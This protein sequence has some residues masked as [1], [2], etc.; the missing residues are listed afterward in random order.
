MYCEICRTYVHQTSKHCRSCDRCVEKFDHHCI[1]INNCIGG[2]NYKVFL[3]MICSAFS[4]FV[5]HLVAVLL[6]TTEYQWENILGIMIAN[7]ISLAICIVFLF[8]IFN[9]ILLHVY[10]NCI[11]LTTYE[12]L[13]KRKEEEQ[14]ELVEERFNKDKGKINKLIAKKEKERISE[15]INKNTIIPFTPVM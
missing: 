11:G 15:K 7:W 12:F 3:V 9:L 2:K 5:E 6:L 8:L 1:W 14:R 13:L 10:L 4:L